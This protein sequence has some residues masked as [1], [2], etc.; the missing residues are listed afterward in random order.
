M[1]LAPGALVHLSSAAGE[2][3]C[4]VTPFAALPF[5]NRSSLRRVSLYALG[6]QV[7]SAANGGICDWARRV[8][9]EEDRGF[10][11][12]EL[13]APAVQAMLAARATCRAVATAA[14]GM[15]ATRV[16]DS[17]GAL[18]EK[19]ATIARVRDESLELSEGPSP[20][21]SPSAHSTRCSARS[22]S[23]SA[24]A[25]SSAPTFPCVS[26][27]LSHL[28]LILVVGTDI[29]NSIGICIDFTETPLTLGWPSGLRRNASARALLL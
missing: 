18:A 19:S 3:H 25:K 22:A 20:P 14:E 13:T 5:N 17:G 15:R 29:C 21:A 8:W 10:T 11:L 16:Y 7:A 1:R 26:Y 24:S 6:G 9:G 28:V 23:C 12:V 4:L 2:M 27:S